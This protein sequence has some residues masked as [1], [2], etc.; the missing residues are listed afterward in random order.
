MIPTNGYDGQNPHCKQLF[1][2]NIFT[3]IYRFAIKFSIPKGI[4]DSELMID[5]SLL[6]SSGVNWNYKLWRKLEKSNLADKKL[7][8]NTEIQPRRSRIDL[9]V[10]RGDNDLRVNQGFYMFNALWWILRRCLIEYEKLELKV[11]DS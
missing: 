11:F 10:G 1:P 9:V 7:I 6:S 3:C 4:I 8:I 2:P 5:L